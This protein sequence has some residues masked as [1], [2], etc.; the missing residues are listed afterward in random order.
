[1]AVEHLIG[2][3]NGRNIILIDSGKLEPSLFENDKE[4]TAHILAD[5]GLCTKFSVLKKR[6][7]PKGKYL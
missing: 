6:Y 5:C 1:M 7:S 2:W 4:S 3:A